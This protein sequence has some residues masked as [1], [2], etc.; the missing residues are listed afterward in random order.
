MTII[1][2][3]WFLGNFWNCLAPRLFTGFS[4]SFLKV[5][6]HL[7]EWPSILN[8]WQGRVEDC[9]FQ[10][11][12]LFL[13]WLSM[14]L[15]MGGKIASQGRRDVIIYFRKQQFQSQE[16]VSRSGNCWKVYFYEINGVQMVPFCIT[17]LMASFKS[18]SLLT[19][20]QLRGYNRQTIYYDYLLQQHTVV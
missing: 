16:T 7:T 4:L 19:Y 12:F 9:D 15:K 2:H 8:Q 3:L 11:C 5:W 20:Q 6:L 1:I 14:T 10:I 17:S 18:G 13:E